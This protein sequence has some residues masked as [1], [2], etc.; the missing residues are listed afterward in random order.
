[1]CQSI[2]G[3]KN[4]IQNKFH[5]H[6]I[7]FSYQQEE[8]GELY[9]FTNEVF[10]YLDEDQVKNCDEELI[11]SRRRSVCGSHHEWDQTVMNVLSNLPT[12]S[13]DEFRNNIYEDWE[14]I[15]WDYTDKIDKRSSAYRRCA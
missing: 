4:N 14:N 12:L 5:T 2:G 9:D 13:D 10:A 7:G 6:V 3:Q 1:M 8:D 15:T 11:T